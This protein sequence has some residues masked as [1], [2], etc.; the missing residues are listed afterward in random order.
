MILF[1]SPQQIRNLK[2][3]LNLKFLTILKIV[4]I[5]YIYWPSGTDKIFICFS[6]PAQAR[7]LPSGE[8][9]IV[10]IEPEKISS[11]LLIRDYS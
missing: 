1:L 7:S 8:K 6:S 10:K 4:F 11:T 9:F 5:V 3:Q 2:S